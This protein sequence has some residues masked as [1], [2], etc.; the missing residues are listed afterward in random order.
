MSDLGAIG[1]ASTDAESHSVK[2][3]NPIIVNVI[4]NSTTKRCLE[5][6]VGE[7]IGLLGLLGFS[8]WLSASVLAVPMAPRSLN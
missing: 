6:Q 3:N 5:R 2:P 1:T 7:D 4:T 8:L